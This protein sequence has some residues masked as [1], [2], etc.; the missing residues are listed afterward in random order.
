MYHACQFIEN[1]YMNQRLSER[2]KNKHI[3]FSNV[4]L[5]D[6]LVEVRTYFFFFFC[7][8]SIIF[9]E[10]I[11][12]NAKHLFNRIPNDILQR[13]IL[14][15]FV[16]FLFRRKGPLIVFVL[17]LW[18]CVKIKSIF[19]NFFSRGTVSISKNRS[20]Q[21]SFLCCIIRMLRNLINDIFTK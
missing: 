2:E 11:C 16:C 18:C 8:F 5:F 1:C 3:F 9:N 6:L 21:G 14:S 17:N 4:V 20:F 7:R 13:E 10:H 15:N 12:W 19:F